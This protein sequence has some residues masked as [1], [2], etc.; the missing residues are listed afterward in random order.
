[1]SE[2]KS[3][4]ANC[5]FRT[6]L[7]APL[8]RTRIGPVWR[9]TDLPNERIRGRRAGKEREQGTRGNALH[10]SAVLSVRG[11]AWAHDDKVR[12]EEINELLI[13]HG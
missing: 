12:S 9:V 3:P 13:T 7:Y 5:A 8:Y 11:M 10:S 2:W 1:M 4:F 6:R